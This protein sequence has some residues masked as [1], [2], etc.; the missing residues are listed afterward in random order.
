M[1]ALVGALAFS[2]VLGARRVFDRQSDWAE[3]IEPASACLDGLVQDLACSLIPPEGKAPFF[4]L[5]ADA[6]GSVLTCVT[7]GPPG[8]DDPGGPLSRFRVWRVTWQLEPAAGGEEPA[9]VRTAELERV[10]G[11]AVHKRYRLAGVTGF[12]VRVYDPA[13]REWVEKWET[14]RSGALPPAARA[15]LTVKTSRGS[16]MLS[17]DTIIPA[18]MRIGPP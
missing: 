5:T 15:G 18:G 1:L 6:E 7:A 14:G 8:E 10:S 11:E 3:R 2:L 16:Q 17:T 13:K 4:R 9:L 12:D